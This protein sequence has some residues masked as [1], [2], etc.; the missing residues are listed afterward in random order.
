MVN[1]DWGYVI[2]HFDKSASWAATD[3]SAQCFPRQFSDVVE[4]EVKT[5]II[6]IRADDGQFIKSGINGFAFDIVVGDRMQI[7]ATDG[8]GDS[9]DYI[10]EIIRKKPIKS[11]REGVMLEVEL[12]GLE[13]W[14]QK[15]HYIKRHF[16]STPKAAM[17]DLVDS[18]NESVLT[19]SLDVPTMSI[20]RNELPDENLLT[21][22]W[23]VNE[24][25]IF[26]R[27][28]ELKD[29]MGG[30]AVSGGVLDFF[31][32][33]FETTL[34]TPTV[35][36]VQVFSSGDA[37]TKP[38]VTVSSDSV[39]VNTEDT[40]AG[41][42]E[43]DGTQIHAWGSNDGGTLPT[44]YSKFKSRDIEMPTNRGSDSLFPEWNSAFAYKIG[45]LVKYTAGAVNKVYKALTDNTNSQPN[46]NPLDWQEQTRD[47]YVGAIQYSP[48]TDGQSN[49]WKSSGADPGGVNVN[50]P[51]GPA[52][53][54]ANIVVND[55]TSFRTWV[56]VK[57]LDDILPTQWRY[58]TGVKR[59][60]T[61]V[62]I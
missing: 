32:I 26:N 14:T 39:N 36:D 17:Q 3:I 37:P 23:G 19:G 28:H 57:Q 16:A 54:D 22:D 30:S 35:I 55:D 29:V 20:S 50:A 31:D 18:Y 8:A 49:W 48:W 13:R 62:L 34:D 59:P 2:K 38:T 33:R 7:V 60:G 44:N 46:T 15:I 41:F 42:E 24:D 47:N 27:M 9:W 52:M 58:P 10:Y 21:L 61:R 12:L 40:D 4:D 43:S 56:D 51:F 6:R 25:T 45:A 1:S 11:K 53:W 5:A